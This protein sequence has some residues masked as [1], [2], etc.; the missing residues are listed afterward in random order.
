MISSSFSSPCS[1]SGSSFPIQYNPVGRGNPAGLPVPGLAGVDP[2]FHSS[3]PRLAPSL[4]TAVAIQPL[5]VMW[6]CLPC[7]VGGSPAHGSWALSKKPVLALEGTFC[8]AGY[9][10]RR[11]DVGCDGVSAM[12]DILQ[13]VLKEEFSFVS[14]LSQLCCVGPCACWILVCSPHESLLAGAWISK[15]H[16]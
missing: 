12:R 4:S 11:N 6:S 9:G 3:L 8:H 16:K 7:F 5:A 2:C 10:A 1:H 15:A 13:G 14:H